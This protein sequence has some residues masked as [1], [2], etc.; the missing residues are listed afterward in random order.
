MARTKMTQRAMDQYRYDLTI[1]LNFMHP[2][3][4]TKLRHYLQE[5]HG[6]DEQMLGMVYRFCE[7]DAGPRCYME[8][9]QIYVSVGWLQRTLPDVYANLAAC[10]LTGDIQ[11]RPPDLPSKSLERYIAQQ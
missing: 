9:R 2:H 1:A 6:I 10:I 11:L 8:P 3:N 5:H 4:I 7:G